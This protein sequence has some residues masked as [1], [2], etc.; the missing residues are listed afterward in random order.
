AESPMAHFSTA[1]CLR[2]SPSARAPTPFP[3][4]PLFRSC[5]IERGLIIEQPH[6]EGWKGTNAPPAPTIGTAHLEESLHAH[7]GK[8]RRQVIR[9]E[10]HTSELQSREKLVC[11][12]LLEKKKSKRSMPQKE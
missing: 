12:L 10:E 9:S 4:T 1:F 8:E 2:P 11:R 6:P 7:L 3:S 5:R